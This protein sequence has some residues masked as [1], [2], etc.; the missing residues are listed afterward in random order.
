MD[1]TKKIYTAQI[2][3]TQ[4]HDL[5]GG[6]P[7]ATKK[8]QSDAIEEVLSYS[9]SINLTYTPVIEEH[10]LSDFLASKKPTADDNQV[11]TAS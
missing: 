1:N 2:I 11:S 5:Y 7:W 9:D 8:E 10:D 6:I 4:G 3:F